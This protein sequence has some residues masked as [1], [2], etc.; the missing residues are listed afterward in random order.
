M[1]KPNFFYVGA[2]KCGSTWLFEALSGH[3]EVSLYPG[4]YTHFFKD[5]YEKGLSWYESQFDS[6]DDTPV[7]GD[8]ETSY[9]FY[10]DV[11]SRIADTYP[12]AK[13]VVSLRNPVDR[14]WSAY[15][16]MK[17][18]SQIGEHVNLADA[19]DTAPDFLTLCSSYGSGVERLYKNFDK[20]Q[21]LILFYDELRS[22]SA[23]YMA[24]VYS[25]LGIDEDHI[26]QNLNKRS[27]KTKN[28]RFRMLNKVL[29]AA[30]WKL[31]SLGLG[32]LVM[33]LKRSSII[34]SI[35]F[36]D[37]KK[38]QPAMSAQER[39]FLIQRNLPEIEKLEHILKIDLN[40]WKV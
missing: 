40:D 9:M 26:P 10:D 12:A 2:P 36:K 35:I 32:I 38:V 16:F 34:K 13:L 5:F 4:K 20:N 14:D 39:E 15:K 21:V 28:S 29:K 23:S 22:D 3:P 37:S 18:T 24:K 7:V 1:P 8:F 33:R 6:V 17:S 11:V 25:F 30:A 31:R 19:M 27:Y